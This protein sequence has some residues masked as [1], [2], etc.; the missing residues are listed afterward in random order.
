ML[1][2]RY[3]ESN[4]QHFFATAAEVGGAVRGEQHGS[5]FSLR[6]AAERVWDEAGRGEVTRGG[7]VRQ[8]GREPNQTSGPAL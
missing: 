5:I 2:E 6:T 1:V 7:G 8:F 3:V 4:T